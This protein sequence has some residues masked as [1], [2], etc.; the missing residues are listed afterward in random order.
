M[1]W[2]DLESEVRT[3]NDGGPQGALWGIL[4]YLSR[5]NRNTDF[6][7]NGKKFKLI[8]DLSILEI[9]NIL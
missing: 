8:D 7:P 4:E 6:V 9:I 5:S 3:L 1:K 2:H